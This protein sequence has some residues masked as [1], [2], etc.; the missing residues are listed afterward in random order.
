MNPI[1]LISFVSMG[2]ALGII[3]PNEVAVNLSKAN[4]MIIHSSFLVLN[5]CL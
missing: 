4:V 5:D 2:A 1:E 3:L